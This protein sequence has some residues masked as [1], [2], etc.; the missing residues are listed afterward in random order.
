M[1]SDENIS[2]LQR[3]LDGNKTPF[4]NCQGKNNQIFA[5]VACINIAKMS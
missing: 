1:I 3:Y 5:S 4:I 2:H